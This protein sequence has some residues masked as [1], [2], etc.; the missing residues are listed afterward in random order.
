MQGRSSRRVVVTGLGVV[1][2]CG[3]GK[4]AYWDGLLKPVTTIGTTRAVEDFDPNQWFDNP[5]EAR[6]ADRFQQFAAA[7]A[8]LAFEDA[9]GDPPGD[10]G[11]KGV[12]LGTGVGGLNTLEEQIDIRLHKGERRV[13]PFLVPMMMANAAGA[14]LSMRFGWQGPCE[15]IVTACAAS[16]HSIGHAARLIAWGRCDAMLTG[17]SEASIT[18][19]A[20]A[21]FVNMTAMTSS[22]VSRPFDERRDGFVMSEAA[23][24]LVLEELESARA[25]GA[26][27][28]G[29][30]L[31]A[32]S[33]AD[34][35]H[36]T[37]PAPGGTGAVTCMELC[38][39][40][41][42]LRTEDI[43]H[44]NAH[45]TSTPLNDAAEAEA[46]T[47]LFGSSGPP[48]TSTKGVTGHALGAAGALEAAAVLLAMEHRVIPPTMGTAAVDPALSI[49]LVVGEP[50]PWDPGPT[51]SNSFGFGGHN[52]CMA[53]GPPPA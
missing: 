43:R 49:D 7:A 25:R 23:T 17:G 51:L 1:A 48:V 39:E 42:E 46:I 33:N 2:P 50:R 24:V 38:L 14:G 41:A 53:I 3:T 9:G 37:A 12:V 11:R 28:L 5:K 19:T 36:I 29:E 30:I 40:D 31:G 18:P 10:P 44:I 35:H 32:A 13:S 6:R 52:G 34:A 8:E 27:I 4:D 22:G 47:K 16:T 26:R 20:I 21:G 45:G 15:T